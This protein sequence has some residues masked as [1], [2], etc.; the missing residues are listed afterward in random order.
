MALPVVVGAGVTLGVPA[1][2]AAGLVV[3]VVLRSRAA[4]AGLLA[5]PL[6]WWAILVVEL[7]RLPQ[8]WVSAR[9]AAWLDRRPVSGFAAVGY[10]EPSLMFAAGTGT[11]FLDAG[12]AARFLAADCGRVVAVAEPQVRPFLIA[13][14]RLAPHAFA[15]VRGFD[16]SVGR[17]VALTLFRA[18]APKP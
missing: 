13:A 8:L 6:L 7:P 5:V 18:G 9:V 3:A 12:A 15:A 16:Y 10:A 11:Q 17:D 4:W 14:G 2:L 1:A